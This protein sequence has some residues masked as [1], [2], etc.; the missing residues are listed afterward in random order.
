MTETK[1]SSQRHCKMSN[2][3]ALSLLP[4]LSSPSIPLPLLLSLTL[5]S[6]HHRHSVI[7]QRSLCDESPPCSLLSTH[8]CRGPTPPSP[9]SCPLP[10]VHLPRSLLCPFQWLSVACATAAHCQASQGQS[11]IYLHVLIKGQAPQIPGSILFHS[12]KCEKE[13][14]RKGAAFPF[15]DT[16]KHHHT[17]ANQSKTTMNIIQSKVFFVLFFHVLFYMLTLNSNPIL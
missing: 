7:M 16:C 14:K 11:I 6:P 8:P 9:A 15:D 5:L 17:R 1:V 12:A 2:L 4:L 3:F 13:N 10:T